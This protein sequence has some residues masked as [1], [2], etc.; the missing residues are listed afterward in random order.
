M[1]PLPSYG[2]EKTRGAASHLATADA[3]LRS[4]LDVALRE[5]CAANDSRQFPAALWPEVKALQDEVN[6]IADRSRD[7]SLKA[8]LSSMRDEDVEH[9]AERLFNLYVKLAEGWD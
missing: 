6:R 7:G 8:A 9:L 2:L 1:S 4:R 3:P 5:F